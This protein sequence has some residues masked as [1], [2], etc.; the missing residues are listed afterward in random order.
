M[1]NE[2]VFKVWLHPEPIYKL[3]KLYQTQLKHLE[4]GVLAI[5]DE[6]LAEKNFQYD[7]KVKKQHDTSYK[8]I[9]DE[10]KPQIFID[11]L[12]E[13][14]THLSL[15]EIKDEINTIMA[16]VCYYYKLI[17]NQQLIISFIGIRYNCKYIINSIIDVGY[18]PRCP[19]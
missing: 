9:D 6:I 16:A 1:L 2:R 12:F 11:H 10:K 7:N 17:F 13:L 4:N 18:T 8:S 5:A 3:T 15:E 14:R 19:R